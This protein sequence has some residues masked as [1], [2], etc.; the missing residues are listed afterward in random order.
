M[1]IENKMC[2]VHESLIKEYAETTTAETMPDNGM[3]EWYQYHSD[4]VI[5]AKDNF[6][7]KKDFLI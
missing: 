4:S 3:I 2:G 5:K 1:S 6:L 7:K